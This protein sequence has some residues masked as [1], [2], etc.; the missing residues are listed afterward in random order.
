MTTLTTQSSRYYRK[1]GVVGPFLLALAII[2][3]MVNPMFY[4]EGIIPWN[5]VFAEFFLFII[6]GAISMFAL[7][8]YLQNRSSEKSFPE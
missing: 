8:T 3:I 2:L 4:P 5:T 1:L 6:G 7:V